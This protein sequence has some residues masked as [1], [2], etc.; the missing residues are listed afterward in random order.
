MPA[1][2]DLYE[3]LRVHPRANVERIREAYRVRTLYRHRH[4]SIELVGMLERMAEA[5][6]TLVDPDKR[7]RYDRERNLYLR[8]E[9]AAAERAA[10]T[11]RREGRMLR[12]YARRIAREADSLGDAA[13]ERNAALLGTLDDEHALEQA[14]PDR[15]ALRRQTLLRALGLALLVAAAA[16]IAYLRLSA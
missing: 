1:P 6:D 7:K 10:E 9:N 16:L 14:P 13:V 11:L 15:G 12:R 4:G 8:D 5:R 3:L 2:P